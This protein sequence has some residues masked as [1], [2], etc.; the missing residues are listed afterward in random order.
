M[1]AD[2]AFLCPDCSENGLSVSA[3]VCFGIRWPDIDCAPIKYWFQGY[4]AKG[5]MKILWPVAV[6]TLTLGSSKD[7][8]LSQ[9]ASL[10]LRN[11][12]NSAPNNVC[13]T[14]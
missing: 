2:I 12:Y 10:I 3:F 7:K 11:A 9:L 5:F 13:P 6:V 14:H 1:K 4:A 8:F